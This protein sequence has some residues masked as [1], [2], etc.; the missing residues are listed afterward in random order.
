MTGT[1]DCCF[2]GRAGSV[3]EPKVSASGALWGSFSVAVGH[4]DEATWVRVSVFGDLARDLSERLQK[5]DRVYC[6]GSLKLATWTSRDGET[7]TGLQLA[8]H[9]VT[10]MK[11]KANKPK[12]KGNPAAAGYAK[13]LDTDAR[14]ARQMYSHTPARLDADAEIPF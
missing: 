3:P 7:R 11:P 10:R 14:P 6:E 13:P 4:G 5:G 9:H 1:I 8:A 12:P 2:T